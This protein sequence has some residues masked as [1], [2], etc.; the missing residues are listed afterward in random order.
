M[1]RRQLR[2]LRALVTGASGGIGKAIALE[3]A[4]Q[5]VQCLLVAR[6]GDRLAEVRNE[7]RERGTQASVVVGDITDRGD[8]HTALEFAQRELGGLDLLVNNA[9]IS[10]SGDFATGSSEVLRQIFEVNF[11]G[12]VELTREAIPMLRQGRSPMIVN[13]GSILGHRGI[14]FTGDYCASKFALTG[15]SQSLR[16]ELKAEGIEVLLVSPGTTES[17][18]AS[19]LIEQRVKLPWA[20]MKGVTAERVARAT[21]R[22]IERGKHEIVP[23]WSGWWMLFAHRLAPRTV[24]TVMARLARRTR[25]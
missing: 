3:L 20:G 19:Q 24:D 10:A 21:V 23:N 14:P 18:L 12:A 6:N 5:G 15:W 11:F 13:I 7:T 22:A 25:S 16:A 9:G 8:R 17:N 2:G 1:S 4:R